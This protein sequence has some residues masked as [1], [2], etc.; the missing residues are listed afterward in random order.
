[1]VEAQDDEVGLFASSPDTAG[2]PEDGLS[3]YELA[4]RLANGTMDVTI[5]SRR[6]RHLSFSSTDT[7][8]LVAAGMVVGHDHGAGH[9]PITIA[10]REGHGAEMNGMY[11]ASIED[12]GML[13]GRQVYRHTEPMSFEYGEEAA[14]KHLA[15]WFSDKDTTWAISVDAGGTDVLAFVPGDE[16]SFAK[17]GSQITGA[18]QVSN[19]EGHYVVDRKVQ[20]GWTGPS[21]AWGADAEEA[22]GGGAA[23]ASAGEAQSTGGAAMFPFTS[24]SSLPSPSFAA[25]QSAPPP[26]QPL[27]P[28]KAAVSTGNTVALSISTDP[29]PPLPPIIPNTTSSFTD[30]DTELA[31]PYTPPADNPGHM[32]TRTPAPT[33][34]G[35]RPPTPAPAP[36][37][38]PPPAAHGLVAAAQES[39]KPT[40]R[41]S[42]VLGF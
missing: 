4:T 2:V 17:A 41:P 34:G 11:F 27:P 40:R 21:G 28:L 39:T 3:P 20:A 6:A 36:A 31:V 33:L 15:L 13:N 42:T 8:A 5:A 18:W 30:P 10:R 35:E 14:G 37:P 29:L 19:G 7:A 16:L 9:L 23:V 26:E 1:L 24:P 32:H 12:D 22:G 38:A 25:E